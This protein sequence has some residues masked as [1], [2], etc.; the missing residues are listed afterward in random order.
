MHDSYLLFRTSRVSSVSLL[1]CQH[2]NPRSC[3]TDPWNN[4]WIF[5]TCRAGDT[6]GPFLV[7]SGFND[8]GDGCEI[9]TVISGPPSSFPPSTT[10]RGAGPPLA[11]CEICSRDNKIKPTTLILEYQPIGQ[12][13]QYQEEKKASCRAGTYPTTTNVEIDG[14]SFG[15]LQAGARFKVEGPFGANSEFTFG[16]G[17]NS[18]T[19]HTS[20]S[21]PLV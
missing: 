7:V 21:V 17:G 16:N 5:S 8:D 19:I 15:P 10:S 18:C 12:N 2:A 1:L 14:V 20:C 3:S 13:S 9:T 4:S 11:E 6:I